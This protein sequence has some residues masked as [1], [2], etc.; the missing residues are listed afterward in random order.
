METHDDRDFSQVLVDKARSM[1][2]Q[3]LNEV[4]AGKPDEPVIE[5]V[6][7]QVSICQRPDDPFALR[8]SIGEAHDLNIAFGQPSV[9]LVFRGNRQDILELLERALSAFRASHFE[10][11]PDEVRG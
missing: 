9:Y 8:I 6:V 7:G 4:T 10:Q 2:E 1:T 3:K 5:Q 11:I